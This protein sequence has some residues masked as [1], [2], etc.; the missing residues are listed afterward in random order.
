MVMGG[1][2][3]SMDSTIVHCWDKMV[4]DLE[5]ASSPVVGT[6]ARSSQWTEDLDQEYQKYLDQ[7]DQTTKSTNRTSTN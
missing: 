5:G 1:S 2:P 3:I 6:V 4:A 7:E